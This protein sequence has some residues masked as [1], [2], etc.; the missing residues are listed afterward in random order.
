LETLQQ[1]WDRI[2]E[3]QCDADTI[4]D[5]YVGMVPELLENLTPQER[6]RVYRMLRLEVLAY[7]DG[8]LEMTGLVGQELGLCGGETSSRR[9]CSLS[10]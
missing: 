7:P 3:L 4:M 10:R 2:A 8:S 1:R 5:Y 9:S 6:H